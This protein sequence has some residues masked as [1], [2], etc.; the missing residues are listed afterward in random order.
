VEEERPVG[1]GR[2]MSETHREAAPARVGHDVVE[3]HEAL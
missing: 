3:Y 1:D 2:E